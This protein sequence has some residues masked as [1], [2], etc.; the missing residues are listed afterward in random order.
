MKEYH[1]NQEVVIHHILEGTLAPH[2]LPSVEDEEAPPT[3]NTPLVLEEG[4][5]ILEARL[6]AY[7]YDE[8]DVFRRDDVDLSKIHIGKKYMT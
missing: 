4:Q 3:E 2:L 6:G 7:D 5:S 1:Y 8:F